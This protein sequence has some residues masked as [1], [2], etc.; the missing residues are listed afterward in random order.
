MPVRFGTNLNNP[1]VNIR[2]VQCFRL[3]YSKPF[4]LAEMFIESTKRSQFSK[5][6]SGGVQYVDPQAEVLNGR[7]KIWC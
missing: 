2:A 7:R 6:F 5:R 4:E 1:D 3:P